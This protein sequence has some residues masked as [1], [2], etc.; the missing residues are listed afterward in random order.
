M[1]YEH[2]IQIKG[3]N[4]VE[5]KLLAFKKLSSLIIDIILF[6]DALYQVLWG[7]L[8]AI[9]YFHYWGITLESSK[10]NHSFQQT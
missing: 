2:H 1:L 5:E 7:N 3:K 9:K 6:R 10:Q 4:V 8:Y